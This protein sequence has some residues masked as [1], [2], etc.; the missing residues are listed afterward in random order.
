MTDATP[1]T[2]PNAPW[3]LPR[4][5][6]GT[7][8]PMIAWVSTSRPPPPM[9]WTARKAISSTMFLAWPQRAEPMRKITMAPRNR[10]LRPYWSPSL[11]QTWV[12]AVEASRYAVTTDIDDQQLLA[13][14]GGIRALGGAAASR[15]GRGARR[16]RVSW[17]RH[18]ALIPR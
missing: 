14:G 10:Y 16:G 4:S 9:P 15:R 6:A 1:K 2:A 18:T 11:P 5:R 13:V 3:Y 8:S 7:M 17:C 12:L